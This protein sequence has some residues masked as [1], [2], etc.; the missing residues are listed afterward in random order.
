MLGFVAREM[1]SLQPGHNYTSQ[2]LYQQVISKINIL[3]SNNHQQ[4]MGIYNMVSEYGESRRTTMPVQY[5]N[6]NNQNSFANDNSNQN[7]N[8]TNKI[9]Q[10]SV[11]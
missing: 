7:R 8:I 3:T 5:N 1:L 2:P 4:R 11:L 6:N 9:G 10:T